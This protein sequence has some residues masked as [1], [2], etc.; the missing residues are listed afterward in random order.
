MWLGPTAARMQVTLTTKDMKP[1]PSW[2]TN[3]DA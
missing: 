1:T 3:E 2:P